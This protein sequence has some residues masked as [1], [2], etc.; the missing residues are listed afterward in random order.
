MKELEAAELKRKEEIEERVAKA[1]RE[2]MAQKRKEAAEERARLAKEAKELKKM[3]YDD[4]MKRRE[5][6]KMRS[7]Y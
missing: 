2:A 1:Q 3:I 7:Q 6:I 5:E 4:E